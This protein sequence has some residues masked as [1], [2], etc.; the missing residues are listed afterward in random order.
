M[1]KAQI[2]L[3][4]KYPIQE[5]NQITK[6]D[7]SEKKLEGDLKLENFVNLKELDCGSNQLTGLDLSNI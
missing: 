4:N 1:V 3:D 7:I 6:L 5:R 2:W